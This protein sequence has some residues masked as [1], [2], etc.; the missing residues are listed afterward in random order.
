MTSAAKTH[1][2]KGKE[3]KREKQTERERERGGPKTYN[4]LREGEKRP[5]Q[6]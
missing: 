3:S 5:R 2:E 6:R 1:C 4:N